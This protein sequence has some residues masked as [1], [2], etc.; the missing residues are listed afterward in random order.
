M[1]AARALGLL[2]IGGALVAGT[3]LDR[4]PVE[5]P[6]RAGDQLVL[7]ADFHVHAFVGDGGV[8]PWELGR[9]ARRRKLDVIVV[10]NHNQLL[11]ARLSAVGS[12]LYGADQNALIIPAEELT[13]PGF[14][15]IAAGI[16][17]TIDWR[18]PAAQ[19]I[20]AIHEQRGVAIAAHPGLEF[21]P[22]YDEEARRLL[23]GSEVAHPAGR[24]S[25][26]AR[27]GMTEFYQRSAALKPTLAPIGSSDF[28]FG[29]TLGECRTF[30]FA[31]EFSATGVLDAIR[32]GST[33]ASDGYGTLTG[34]HARVAI[35]RGLLAADPP[36]L[37][38]S[39]PS[40]IA[41][42]VS[43]LGILILLLLK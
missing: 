35:V 12:W 10:S 16:T 41:A 37:R 30:V 5:R 27:I 31:D 4:V 19:A 20:A 14:H 39:W 42:F 11:A 2:L 22:A 21:W 43:V 33:V 40:R 29:A 23:D 3:V 13:T 32:R 24:R 6:A 34:D 17:R 9:E 36:P 18:L 8:P 7:A 1:T 15:M 26:D 25:A 28:H 38:P